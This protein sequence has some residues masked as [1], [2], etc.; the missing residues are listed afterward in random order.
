METCNKTSKGNMD[1]TGSLGELLAFMKRNNMENMQIGKTHKNSGKIE[2]FDTACQK[3]KQRVKF[4]HGE[5]DRMAKI[6]LNKE[7]AMEFERKI[8]TME[9]YGNT[10][11]PHL[12]N[13]CKRV[14]NWNERKQL[15]E[16]GA[17]TNGI[18]LREACLKKRKKN[19]NK[20]ELKITNGM[21]SPTC[22]QRC[23]CKCEGLD[24]ACHAFFCNE[25][26]AN[27]N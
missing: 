17:E 19:L 27:E 16:K 3:L 11:H 13:C 23:C 26:G 2:D 14:P 25:E 1:T 5:V 18:H 4:L 24:N 22:I 21:I 9:I 10:H 8:G 7:N 6:T 15:I 20:N 12:K